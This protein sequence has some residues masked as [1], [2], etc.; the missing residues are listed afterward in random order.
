MTNKEK[1]TIVQDLLPNYVEKLTSDSTNTFIKEHLKECKECTDILNNMKKDFEKENN[2]IEKEVDYAKKYNMKFKKMKFTLL[3]VIYTIIFII[4]AFFT[5]NF[6]VFKGIANKMENYLQSNNYYVRSY[7][8]QG[9]NASTT[10]T[11]VKDENMIINFNNELSHVINNGMLYSIYG[12][13]GYT[14]ENNTMK[15]RAGEFNFIEMLKNELNSPKS[16]FTYSLSTAIVNGKDC[17]M[18]KHTNT[19]LYFEKSTGYLVRYE[20]LEGFVSPNTN[21]ENDLVYEVQSTIYDYK[22]EFN[23]VTDK[24]LE[25][26]LSNL[27]QI[28]I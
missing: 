19:I 4:I 23:Q 8:Y 27:K 7:F 24:D 9:W 3:I 13:N 2:N 14:I 18:L 28:E 17:Y 20:E 6:I 26:D 10:E 15:V 1:C 16:I 5:R 21:K 22:F 25:F 12:E 11:W